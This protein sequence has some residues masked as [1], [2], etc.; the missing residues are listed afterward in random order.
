MAITAILLPFVTYL[1]T[2]LHIYRFWYNRFAGGKVEAG[3]W[4]QTDRNSRG[5]SYK[6][7]GP[8]SAPKDYW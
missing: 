8:P 7:L 2:L 5:K 3:A 6:S 1:L 4:C